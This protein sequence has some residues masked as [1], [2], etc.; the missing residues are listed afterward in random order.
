[1][2]IYNQTQPKKHLGIVISASHNKR[3]D[4]GVKITNFKG[5]MLEK[6]IEPEVEVFVNEENFEAAVG[7]FKSFLVK[8]GLTVYES[9]VTVLIGGDTRP[10]TEPLLELIGEGIKSQNGTAINFHLTT[11]PQLQFYGTNSL[12]KF[13]GQIWFI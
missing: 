13:I 8:K 9:P 7:N 11:T 1:V 12:I 4:N 5:N 3:E 2:A 6:D 10:S